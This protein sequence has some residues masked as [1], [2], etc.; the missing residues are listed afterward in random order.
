MKKLSPF[1]WSLL[2]FGILYSCNPVEIKTGYN[3]ITQELIELLNT[4]PEVNDLLRSSIEHA[5]RVNPDPKTN[6]VQSLDHYFDFVSRTENGMPWSLYE[7]KD[8]IEVYSDISKSLRYFYFLINQPLPELEGKGLYDNTIQYSE[9]FATWLTKFN[10]HWGHYLS[11]EDSWNETYYQMAKSDTLFGLSSTWYEDPS[12]WK[13]FNDFFARKL[14]SPEE[15]PITAPEDNQIVSSSA[16]S[17]PIGSWKIDD[18]SVIISEN[19]IPVK[20]ATFRSVSKLIGEESPYAEAFKNGTYIHSF[21]AIND[22][23][24]YHFPL[25]GV[26]KEVSLI[27]GLGVA[28]GTLNWDAQNLRYAYNPTGIDWQMLETRGCIILE[29][30]EFGLVALIPVG[31]ATISSVNFEESVK[32]GTY[33]KKGDPLGYFLFGGSD[34]VML[35]QEHVEFILD[36]PKMEGGSG[37]QHRLMGERIGFLSLKKE[38]LQN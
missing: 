8:S 12:N 13:S 3:P 23:H 2:L 5:R 1:I 29:T 6:P 11:S 19:G 28:G 24:R 25:S 31:M 21:L 30:R 7:K 35:F 27:Q 9:P 16:D 38:E 20:S 22:Y 33:V 10:K 4:N 37:Y 26:I 15:R 32:V 36:A 34:F 18:K 17:R 14:R